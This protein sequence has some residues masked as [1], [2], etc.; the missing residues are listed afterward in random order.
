[1]RRKALLALLEVLGALV[2]A[3]LVLA[4]GCTSSAQEKAYAP[5]I[6]TADFS[7]TN[8]WYFGEDTKE[9]KNGKVVST[10]GVV[11]GRG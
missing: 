5:R 2:G 10:E 7:T 11:G 3:V 1:M 6:D 9:Y 4:A 8:V